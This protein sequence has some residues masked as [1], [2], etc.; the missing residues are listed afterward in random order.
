ME[1]LK[2]RIGMSTSPTGRKKI[3]HRF[4]GGFWNENRSS[5][6]RDGRA[7]LWQLTFSFAPLGLWPPSTSSPRLKLDGREASL[8]ELVW[9]RL[10]R[11]DNPAARAAECER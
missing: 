1:L 4:I 9:W 6:V 10:S 11:C 5:S 2:A 8:G 3:A 7:R